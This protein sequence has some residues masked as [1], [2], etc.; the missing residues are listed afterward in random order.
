[1]KRVANDDWELAL[2]LVGMKPERR[3]SAAHPMLNLVLHHYETKHRHPSEPKLRAYANGEL[4]LAMPRGRD[5]PFRE[6]IDELKAARSGRGW[7]TPEDR[8]RLERGC[9]SRNSRR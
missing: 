3:Q 9:P 6:N 4:E 7:S 1:M 2:A 8:P 5:R